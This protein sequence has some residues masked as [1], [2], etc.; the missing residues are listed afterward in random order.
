MKDTEG[1]EDCQRE[2]RVVRGSTVGIRRQRIAAENDER[3]KATY[4]KRQNGSWLDFR[5][6]V[7][8]KEVWMRRVSTNRAEIS[9]KRLKRW[10]MRLLV[11]MEGNNPRIKQRGEAEKEG[12]F[13]AER[14]GSEIKKNFEPIGQG[15]EREGKSANQHGEVFA[16]GGTRRDK[17]MDEKEGELSGREQ[18]RKNEQQTLANRRAASTRRTLGRRVVIAGN[19][20][21]RWAELGGK[22]IAGR[23]RTQAGIGTGS[24]PP[25]NQRST[26]G[27]VVILGWREG[28]QIEEKSPRRG[29][30]LLTW[31]DLRAT[32]RLGKTGRTGATPRK[33][34]GRIARKPGPHRR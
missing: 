33:R 19:R 31:W 24:W 15:T 28:R 14:E 7:A 12:D 10:G 30:E 4:Q 1:K 17:K 8:R 13:P 27:T 2:V 20:N 3:E 11:T 21:K 25:T 34:A 32:R 6:Q 29:G 16:C 9:A 26:R 23:G 5:G 22:R 18:G